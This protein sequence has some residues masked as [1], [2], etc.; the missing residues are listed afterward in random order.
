MKFRKLD[1]WEDHN[2]E[3]GGDEVM[4]L[5]AVEVP[6]DQARYTRISWSELTNEEFDALEKGEVVDLNY[7]GELTDRA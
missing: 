7:S 5:E 6:Q 2:R 4:L 3:P 1:E